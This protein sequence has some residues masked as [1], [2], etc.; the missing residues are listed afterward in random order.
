[1]YGKLFEPKKK[2]VVKNGE[3][4]LS[5]I[6]VMRMNISYTGSP[7]KLQKIT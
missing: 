4:L 2:M 3:K 5:K 7:S 1:M 6:F